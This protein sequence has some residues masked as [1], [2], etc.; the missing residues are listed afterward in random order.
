MFAV[1]A[2]T[3]VATPEEFIVAVALLLEQVNAGKGENGLPF[4]S[5]ST[6]RECLRRSD[7]NRRT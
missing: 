6:G 7:V 2:E 1:P 3:P 5:F 4:W